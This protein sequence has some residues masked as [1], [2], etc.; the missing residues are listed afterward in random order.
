MHINEDLN[1]EV[2]QH[3]GKESKPWGQTTRVCQL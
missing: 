3:T 2:I 1:R